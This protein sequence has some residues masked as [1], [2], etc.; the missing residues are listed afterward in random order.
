MDARRFKTKGERTQINY[1]FY[2]LIT[3]YLMLIQI[4]K[5]ITKYPHKNPI[6]ESIVK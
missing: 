4:H 3:N 6:L 2:M 1:H 5:D